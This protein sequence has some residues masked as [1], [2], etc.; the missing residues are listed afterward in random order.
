TVVAT[1]G[2][3][4]TSET[5]G[6]QTGLYGGTKNSVPDPSQLE[7]SYNRARMNIGPNTSGTS[8]SYDDHAKAM[9]DAEEQRKRAAQAMQQ[10][11]DTSQGHLDNYRPLPEP[12]PVNIQ[13]EPIND[14]KTGG[15]TVAGYPGV[16]GYRPPG[17][18]L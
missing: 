12:P 16:T 15:T 18:S 4:A 7:N 11:R 10:Y 3:N 6:G 9:A 13:I 14:G 8:L 2:T 5:I 1:D 17:G